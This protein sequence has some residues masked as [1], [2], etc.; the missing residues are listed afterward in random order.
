L[1]TKTKPQPVA[2][3]KQQ[4]QEQ[5]SM[6][7]KMEKWPRKSM[8]PGLGSLRRYIKL[9]SLLSGQ[10]KRDITKYQCQQQNCV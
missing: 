9:F 1:E 7:F 3:R 2:E 8:K 10:T 6:V 4:K 5:K